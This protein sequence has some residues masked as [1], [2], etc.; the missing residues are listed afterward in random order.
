MTCYYI[1]AFPF[2][3][4][5]INISW[6]GFQN[7]S[8]IYYWWHGPWNCLCQCLVPMS[9][10]MSMSRL[11]SLNL[12]LYLAFIVSNYCQSDPR[13]V[14]QSAISEDSH[15]RHT[16][17]SNHKNGFLLSTITRPTARAIHFSASESCFQE[18]FV[19]FNI[20]CFV[21]LL[22]VELFEMSQKR[23]QGHCLLSCYVGTHPRWWRGCGGLTGGWD[24]TPRTASPTRTSAAA[25]G[26]G[27]SRRRRRTPPPLKCWVCLILLNNIYIIPANDLN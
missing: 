1:E 21:I 18:S 16:T 26:T 24:S 4:F 20:L 10:S 8:P 3:L 5:A 19:V 25:C 27:S 2:C 15:S 9:Q 14:A 22:S 23:G 7:K 6:T 17:V 12:S 11:F 13:H